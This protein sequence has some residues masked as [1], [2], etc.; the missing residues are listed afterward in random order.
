MCPPGLSGWPG[1]SGLPPPAPPPPPAP[2]SSARIRCAS[3]WCSL[4]CCWRPR[5]GLGLSLPDRSSGLCGPDTE[6]SSLR[7]SPPPTPPHPSSPEE[8]SPSRSA[9]LPGGE[10]E[11]GAAGESM[12]S[13]IGLKAGGMTIPPASITAMREEPTSRTGNVHATY[14]HDV[15]THGNLHTGSAV[16][17]KHRPSLS[18]LCAADV[19]TSLTPAVQCALWSLDGA[20][21]GRTLRPFSLALRRRWA[22]RGAAPGAGRCSLH[23]RE[24][25]QVLGGRTAINEPINTHYMTVRAPAQIPQ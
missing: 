18:S 5:S 14:T 7:R 19:R 11:T 4:Q 10:S 3:S 24:S 17:A 6:P 23:Y 13:V 22:G 25:V 20:A 12:K 9:R 15:H 2:I 1:Y 8:K 16:L 21:G